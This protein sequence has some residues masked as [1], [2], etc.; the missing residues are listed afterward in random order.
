MYASPNIARF[1]HDH[2]ELEIA[3]DLDD[4]MVDLVAGDYDLAIRIGRLEDSSLIAR[5]LLRA[6]AARPPKGP[7][8]GRPPRP[9]AGQDA[10]VGDSAGR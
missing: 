9:R 8:V 6:H 1:A 2:P 10:A 7:G 3:L 5:K 4:R